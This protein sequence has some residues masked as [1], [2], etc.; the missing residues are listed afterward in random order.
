MKLADLKGNYDAIFSLGDLC[1][2]SIQLEN[3]NLRP[4]AGVLDWL[5]SPNMDDVCQLLSN[6]FAGFMELENLR[7]GG[8]TD[9]GMIWVTDDAYYMISSHDFEADKNSLTHLATYPEVKAKYDRRIQRFL[10]KISTCQRIL[11]VRTEATFE[12]AKQLQQVLMNIVKHDFRVLLV[13]HTQVSGMKEL[14]WPLE[15]VCALE[16]SDLDKWTGNDAHWKEVFKG[17][18]YVKDMSRGGESNDK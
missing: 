2:S 6:R 8:A 7:I 9:T 11:F 15:K 10:N 5:A 16:M 12:E 3:N 17:I 13:N 4:Y 14:D 18:H 1:L